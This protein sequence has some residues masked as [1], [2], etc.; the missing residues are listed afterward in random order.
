MYVGG[1]TDLEI[2]NTDDANDISTF[3]HNIDIKLNAIFKRNYRQDE[4]ITIHLNRYLKRFAIV[5]RDNSDSG[6]S[7]NERSPGFQ[8]Y[9]A[10]LVNKLYLN[11]LHE[12]RNVIYLLDEPGN[13]LHPKGAKD[14]LKTFEEVSTKNQIIYTTHNPFLAL[15]NNLDSLIFVNKKSRRR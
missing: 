14:L 8:Y 2:F 13:N 3:L 15:R 4:S 11:L 7:I 6:F 1:C 9:F 10:F 12:K 5:I